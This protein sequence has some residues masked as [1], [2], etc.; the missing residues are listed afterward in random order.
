MGVFR[1]SSTIPART[2]TDHHRLQTISVGTNTADD[3]ERQHHLINAL[4]YNSYQRM[5]RRQHVDA[6]QAQKFFGVNFSV[7]IALNELDEHIQS[8]NSPQMAAHSFEVDSSSAFRSIPSSKQYKS[9][10]QEFPSEQRKRSTSSNSSNANSV[11]YKFYVQLH[12]HITVVRILLI[13]DLK[14]E[15]IVVG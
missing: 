14:Q 9:L 13:A 12:F 3:D 10:I 15:K 6:N 1:S 5:Q 2:T 4:N 7:P 11:S 8:E